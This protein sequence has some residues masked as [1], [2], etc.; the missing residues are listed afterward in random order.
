MQNIYIKT[1]I[2]QCSKINGNPTRVRRSKFAPDMAIPISHNEK[3]LYSEVQ[4]LNKIKQNMSH[5]YSALK[6]IINCKL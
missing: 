5:A 1:I 2:F 6:A 3:G 4:V